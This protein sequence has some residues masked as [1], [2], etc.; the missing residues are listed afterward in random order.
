MPKGKAICLKNGT[1]SCSFAGSGN[2]NPFS[3]Q[4]STNDQTCVSVGMATANARYT[5][6]ITPIKLCQP[7]FSRAL[8]P[9]GLWCTTLR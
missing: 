8:M 1:V 2:T 4:C 3:N 5:A 7:N 9:L 6:V